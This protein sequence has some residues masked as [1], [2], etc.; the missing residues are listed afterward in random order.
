MRCIPSGRSRG[1]GQLRGALMSTHP[2]ES[3]SY[4]HIPVMFRDEYSESYL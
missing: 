4:T 1:P 3:A 2:T